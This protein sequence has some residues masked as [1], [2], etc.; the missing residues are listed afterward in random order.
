MSGSHFCLRNKTIQM[1]HSFTSMS[2]N[3]IS[4]VCFCLCPYW[5][6]LFCLALLSGPTGFEKKE[7]VWEAA[8]SDWWNAVDHRVP[9]RRF[10]ERQH[11]HWSAQE[12][13]LRCQGHEVCTWKPVRASTQSLITIWLIDWWL[14][15]LLL[16]SWDYMESKEKIQSAL[17]RY[18]D[19]EECALLITRYRGF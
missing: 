19:Y 7:A 2:L 18:K 16:L 10:G 4:T 5:L 6:L 1:I 9:E 11:Q 3:C 12:H 13:W 17:H 8:C 15:S 14:Y